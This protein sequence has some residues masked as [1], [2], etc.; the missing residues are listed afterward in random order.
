MSSGNTNSPPPGGA[1]EYLTFEQSLNELELVVRRLEEGRLSLSDALASYEVGVERLRHCYQLLQ[2][3]ECRIEQLV[4][5]DPEGKAETVPFDDAGAL[6]DLGGK[7]QARAQ[8]RSA[9]KRGVSNGKS[10]K[11]GK[12]ETRGSGGDVNEERGLF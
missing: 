7:Q 12:T 10:G 8:R 3:A 6:D 11:T 1:T 2:Q 9:T 4:R 5:L